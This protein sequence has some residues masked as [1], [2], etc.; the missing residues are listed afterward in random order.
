M[1]KSNLHPWY[2]SPNQYLQC[3]VE[4]CVHVGVIITKAHLRVAHSKTRDEVAESY[5]VP[6][7]VGKARWVEYD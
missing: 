2:A 4:G 1:G 3:P 6:I 5:G 7:P